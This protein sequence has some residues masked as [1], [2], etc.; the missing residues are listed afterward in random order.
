M[1]TLENRG[2]ESSAVKHAT[3]FTQ[4]FKVIAIYVQI[5]FNS[6]VIEA[7]R[8]VERPKFMMPE[9]PKEKT[10]INDQ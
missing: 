8:N 1:V 4:T 7:I 2:F 5:N 3:Q 6:D 10:T 9:D